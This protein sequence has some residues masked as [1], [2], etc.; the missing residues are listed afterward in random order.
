MKEEYIKVG[1]AIQN[2]GFYESLSVLKESGFLPLTEHVE[3]GE[4]FEVIET[5]SYHNSEIGFFLSINFSSSV[6][7]GFAQKIFT[8]NL[9]PDSLI[10]PY[11]DVCSDTIFLSSDGYAYFLNPKH[12]DFEYFDSL[13]LSLYRT[14]KELNTEALKLKSHSRT[15][16]ENFLVPFYNLVIAY[17]LGAVRKAADASISYASERVQGGK[18]IINYFHVSEKISRM[19]EFI[20]LISNASKS[21]CSDI[22]KIIE[23]K[24]SADFSSVYQRIIHP[25]RYALRESEKILSDSI[26]IHGGYGYMKDYH[27]EKYFRELRTIKSL[28]GDIIFTKF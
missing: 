9:K 15:N 3:I 6:V 26:Q 1:R 16:I 8:S 14:K 23:K 5:I 27:L 12:I 20:E 2:L 21:F 19:K 13:S 28:I 22:E 11:A 7:S 24:D 4:L 25:L 18:P 10:F 17:I